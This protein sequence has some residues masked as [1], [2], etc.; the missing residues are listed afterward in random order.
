MYLYPIRFLDTTTNTTA[1][2]SC[3]FSSS[4]LPSSMCPFGDGF[5][6]LITSNADLAE[7]GG[8]VGKQWWSSEDDAFRTN[9]AQSKDGPAARTG[10]SGIRILEEGDGPLSHRPLKRMSSPER[11][12][13][14]QLIASGVLTVNEYPM[15]DEKGDGMMYQKRGLRRSLKLK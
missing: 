5:A 9:P 6:F 13:A 11:W 3:R 1:S 14:K 8:G 4:I 7:C 15:Y 12:E 10:L 2:F